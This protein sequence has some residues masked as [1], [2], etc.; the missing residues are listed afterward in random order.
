MPIPCRQVHKTAF[1]D[2]VD[3]TPVFQSISDDIVALHLLRD[4]LRLES[5]IIHFHIEMARIGQDSPFLHK[6]HML[7]RDDVPAARHRDKHVAEGRRILHGHDG[8]AVHH[9]FDRLDRI[10]FRHN[11]PGAQ[12][13][14]SHRDALAAP[15]VSGHNRL[16]TGRDEVSRLIDRIPDR[17][18][19][20]IAV[21]KEML[22]GRIIDQHD[23]IAEPARAV[24]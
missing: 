11:D 1:R 20:T 2:Q 3:G 24:H 5:R 21:V 8:K 16:L 10:H 14:R 6:E 18:A 13:L 23:R 7:H 9:R 22:H 4:A 15:A 17:L 19:R 12:T